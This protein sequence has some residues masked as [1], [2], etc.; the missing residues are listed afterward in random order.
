MG[1]GGITGGWGDRGG[2]RGQE[3][4]RIGM[5]G[6]VGVGAG[7]QSNQNREDV[8]GSNLSDACTRGMPLGKPLYKQEI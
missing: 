7:I 3:R 8:A 1:A 6:E 2:G 5:G 4:G